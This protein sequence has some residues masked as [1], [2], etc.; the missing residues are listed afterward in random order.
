MNSGAE[1]PF[2]IAAY[3]NQPIGKLCEALALI[4]HNGAAV[5]SAIPLLND[6]C[7]HLLRAGRL[8]DLLDTAE[9]IFSFLDREGASK[10]EWLSENPMAITQWETFGKLML[11]AARKRDIAA[12]PAVLRSN[13]G[14]G[15]A[16]LGLLAR[17]PLGDDA[18][19][20]RFDLSPREFRNCLND[21]W[22][23]DL[24]KCQARETDHADEDAAVSLGRG[25]LIQVFTLRHL[26]PMMVELGWAGRDYLLSR[27]GIAANDAQY[28]ME[29][30]AVCRTGLPSP[31][32]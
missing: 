18:L 9:A 20:R 11:E 2:D 21:L 30:A 24:I 13:G 6:T 3:L 23:C 32:K 12:I 25:G 31:R 26:G 1:T 10:K 29:P 28:E 14:Y 7:I 8:E 17:G 22:E 15:E 19:A 4:P 27:H 16:I 5:A